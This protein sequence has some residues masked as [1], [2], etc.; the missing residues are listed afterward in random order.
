MPNAILLIFGM[1]LP[2]SAAYADDFSPPDARKNGITW[3]PL[4]SALIQTFLGDLEEE[5]ALIDAGVSDFNLRFQRR[6]NSKIGLT[7]QAEYTQFSLFTQTTYVGIRGGPRI[8]FHPNNL[9][10]WSATPFVT[11]GRSSITAGT[12]S[13]ST[14][15]V[16]G[17]GSEINYTWFWGPVLIELGLGGYFTQNIGYRAHAE[18]MQDTTAPDSLSQLKPLLTMGLGYAF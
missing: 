13:L 4:T 6:I 15:F 3:N 2:Y 1:I 5:G 9:K 14:W 16:W 17:A 12:Y 7:L 18:S 11:L 8:F 10:G